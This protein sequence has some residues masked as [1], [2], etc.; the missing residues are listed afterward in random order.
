MGLQKRCV[1]KC[2]FAVAPINVV[3]N[4]ELARN[5]GNKHQSAGAQVPVT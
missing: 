1:K 5:V 3:E 2:V 4:V